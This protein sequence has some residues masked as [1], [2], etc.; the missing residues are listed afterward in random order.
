MRA[1]LLRKISKVED[2]PLQLVEVPTPIPREDEILIEVSVCGVCHT[3]LDEIE[4]R[5][6]PKLPVILG[7][8]IVGRVVERGAKATHYSI[9]DRVGVA[10]IYH[11][12]GECYH[13]KN[14]YENLC[15]RFK[16]T[17]CD[18]DGGYAEYMTVSENFAYPIPSQLT[19]GETAPLLCAGAIGYRALKLTGMQNGETIGL[20]GYGASAHILH[21]VIKYKFPDSKIYV[22][23]KRKG[24]APS[25]L[26]QKLGADWIGV[27]GETPPNKLNRAIDTTPSATVIKEALRNLEKGGRLVINVIR[28]ET[29]IPEMEYS[30]YFWGEKEVKTVANI[31]RKDVQEFLPIAAQLRLKLS[32]T[33]FKLQE[34]NKALLLLKQGKYTGA[35]ILRIT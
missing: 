7:H 10:W 23:T 21:Q 33:E 26:A 18:A 20:Y 1:Q 14:G 28:K 22:F 2:D 8:Q 4:G 12:C 5:L 13:C 29:S 6:I 3:E 35:A 27:T 30:E 19:D 25:Q 16:G 32:I 11:A 34:A 9:G 15:D 17:G 24:D 31:T